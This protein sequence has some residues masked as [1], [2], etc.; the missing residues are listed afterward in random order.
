MLEIGLNL[1][2]GTVG[3][4][5]FGFAVWQW[6]Q[7][8]AAKEVMNRSLEAIVRNAQAYEISAD[9]EAGIVFANQVERQCAALISQ[10]PQV[11]RYFVRFFPGEE[12][13][14]WLTVLGT[15]VAETGDRGASSKRV[16][17]CGRALR[18]GTD[19]LIYGPYET[20]PLKGKYR[21]DFRLAVE[22]APENE[23]SLP[24]VRIDINGAESV[25]AEK[26]LLG[27]QVSNDYEWYSLTFRYVDLTEKLEYRV[28][29]LQKGVEGKLYDIMLRHLG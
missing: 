20:L 3:I 9:S 22:I 28:A 29:L 2:F 7:S 11:G 1:L 4:V 26:T 19:K 16:V 5:G 18:D 15:P 27:S 25:L 12:S 10:P 23:P 24:L 17:M 8:Q 21:V 6:K 13:S 14:H